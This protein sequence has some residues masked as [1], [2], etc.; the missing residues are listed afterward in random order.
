MNLYENAATQAIAT[1]FYQEPLWKKEILFN[2]LLKP[3]KLC[4][5]NIRDVVTQHHLLGTIPDFTIKTDRGNIHFEVK[6]NNVGLTDSETDSDNRDAFLVRRNYEYISE[7][8][9]GEDKILFWEDLFESIDKKG[10]AND[11]AR[12][13]LV[14]EYMNDAEHTILLTPHEVAMV[15]SPETIAAVYTMSAKILKLCNQFVSSLNTNIYRPGDQQQDKDG[16]G[17]YF[18][19]ISGQQRLFFVGIGPTVPEQY[20]FSLALQLEENSKKPGENWYIGDEDWAYC[21]LDKEMLA[22][23]SSEKALQKEFNESVLAIL[24]TLK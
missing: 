3:F 18:R 5:E 10:A 13:A 6:I 23:H 15:Y 1:F 7:I 17:R 14:R 20:S 9:L 8:P 16:I 12:L 22:K 4:L 24:E 11:F 2:F 21:P 19:E